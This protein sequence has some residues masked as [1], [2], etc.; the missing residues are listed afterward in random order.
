MYLPAHFAQNDPA[1][2][3]AAVA[4]SPLGMLVTVSEAGGLDAN[5]LPFEW[6]CSA[7]GHG[8]LRCHVARANP[9]WRDT[10]VLARDAMVVFQGPNAY[11]SPTFYPS[12]QRDHRVVP[13]WNYIA[14]HAHGR[15]AVHD[16]PRWLR[17]LLARLT[18]RFEATQPVP[19][20]MGDAPADYL[21]EQLR[22]IVGLEIAVSRIEGKW[23]VSQNRNAADRQGV[24]DELTA[25]AH[26]DDRAVAGVMRGLGLDG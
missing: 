16:D 17:A 18:R 9:V 6:D 19:W 1:L 23:K 13:T 25:R 21:D 22:H 20:K 11:V 12:K 14:V 2:L 8:L 10:D 15:V 24:V 7:G 26:A 4:Q 5:H 3:Q